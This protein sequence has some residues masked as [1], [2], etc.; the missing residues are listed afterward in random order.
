M[1][2]LSC[3]LIFPRVVVGFQGTPA[4]VNPACMYY[5]SW[6]P[7]RAIKAHVEHGMSMRS[8]A[9]LY[10]ILKR[11]LGDRVSGLVVPGQG[12]P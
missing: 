11:T 10:N 6:S 4:A 12:S 9:E 8:A 1:F 2:C 7:K 5:K 3:H